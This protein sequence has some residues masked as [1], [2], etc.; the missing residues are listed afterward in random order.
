M[1]NLLVFFSFAASACAA[2]PPQTT[3][4]VRYACGDA[5]LTQTGE[6]L[7]VAWSDPSRATDVKLGWV[8][9]AGRHYLAWPLSTTQ[10]STV[11]YVVPNDRHA[12]ATTRVYDTRMGTSSADWRLLS[13]DVCSA[14]GGYNE[15]LALFAGGHSMEDVAAKFG[16]KDSHEARALVHDA[17]ISAQRRYYA[18]R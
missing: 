1:R 4:P 12:D 14:R 17:M 8:D 18:D 11:E 7:V 5:E 6:K 9:D 15:A 16:L 3:T 13:K 2:R 10:V